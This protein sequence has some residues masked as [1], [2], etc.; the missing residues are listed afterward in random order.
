MTPRHH[1]LRSRDADGSRRRF[2][3]RRFLRRRPSTPSPLVFGLTCTLGLLAFGSVAH[4]EEAS[5]EAECLKI[6]SITARKECENRALNPACAANTTELVDTAKLL[7][8]EVDR[9]LDAYEGLLDTDFGEVVQPQ[10]YCRFS[11]KEIDEKYALAAGSPAILNGLQSKASELQ[12]CQRQWEA[13]F[14]QIALGNGGTTD[15]RGDNA[16][17]QMRK[18]LNT[19]APDIVKINDQV[20]KLGDAKRQLDDIAT[21]HVIQCPPDGIPTGKAVVGETR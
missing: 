15:V 12:G 18:D 4:A 11:R 16:I 14:K 9:E 7:T 8:I 5:P 10:Q 2:L 21:Y 6:A 1:A 13:R 3:R 19:L 20:A 17:A